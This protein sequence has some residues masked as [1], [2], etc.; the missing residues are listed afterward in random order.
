M[1]IKFN[2]E[3][4]QRKALAQKIGELTGSE[5]KYL[6]VPSCGYQIGEYTLDKEAVLHG[7]ELPDE[8][9]SELQKAGY[10]A[11]DEPVALTISMP[12]DFFGEQGLE[13]LLQ[14]IENKE[15][16][17]KHALNTESL[18]VNECEETIEFPWFTVEKDGDGDAYARFI[19]ALCEFAKNLKRVVNKP[20]TS[21]NEKYAFRCFLLRL[22]MIG[23]EYKPVR[24]VLLRRL[25]GSSA[26]RHGKPEGGADDAVSE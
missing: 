6:G 13:N 9:R 1:N 14:I 4:S 19:T 17:L 12:R 10:T 22:G 23:E 20:D 16:L 26:F 24:R 18:A 5:V 15:T 2:I 11:E 25:T 21:D 3:K 7:D 8:I